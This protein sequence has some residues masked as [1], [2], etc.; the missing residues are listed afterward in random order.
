MSIEGRFTDKAAMVTGGA[1]GIGLAIARRL[2]AEGASV[3]IADIDRASLSNVCGELGPNSAPMPVDVR[4]EAAVALAVQTAVE[5][6]GT[7][8]LGFN[9]AGLGRFGEITELT[10]T[11]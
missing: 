7:L 11:D 1:S 4:D 3:L 8:D 5:R 9:C 2:I 6:F 10:E